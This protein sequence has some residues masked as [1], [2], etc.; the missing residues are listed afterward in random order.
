MEDTSNPNKTLNLLLSK[1]NIDNICVFSLW[2]Q[3][4]VYIF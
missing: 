3:A 1:D 4:N 2:S